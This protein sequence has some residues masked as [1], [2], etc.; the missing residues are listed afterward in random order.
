MYFIY[1]IT[2]VWAKACKS[3]FLEENTTCLSIR[4][5]ALNPFHL[6][7]FIIGERLISVLITSLIT[8]HFLFTATPNPNLIVQ[9]LFG[10]FNQKDLSTPR[11]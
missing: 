1:P 6:Y 2:I 3:I 9:T 4:T 11:E 10:V 8:Y 5:Y 7:Q